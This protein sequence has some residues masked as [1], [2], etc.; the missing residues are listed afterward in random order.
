MRYMTTSRRAENWQNLL[1]SV[2]R[3]SHAD[4]AM[5]TAVRS[6]PAVSR[7]TQCD[8]DSQASVFFSWKNLDPGKVYRLLSFASPLETDARLR[9]PNIQCFGE[10]PSLSVEPPVRVLKIL[11]RPYSRLHQRIANFQKACST[12]K[13]AS[14]L[15]RHNSI[16]PRNKLFLHLGRHSGKAARKL[17]EESRS[18]YLQ[19]GMSQAMKETI[20]QLMPAQKIS[21]R[22]RIGNWH[23]LPIP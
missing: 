13:D 21:H 22:A 4:V 17:L 18:A 14:F 15:Q 20:C 1:R 6:S 10:V 12:Q 7:C 23:T 5:V 9:S 19:H 2:S 16:H 3:D 11:Q 8:L